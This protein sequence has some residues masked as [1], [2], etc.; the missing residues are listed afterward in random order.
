LDVIG[1]SVTGDIFAEPVGGLLPHM[2]AKKPST[3]K[4]AARLPPIQ[5]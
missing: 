4:T 1:R 3:R 5:I 2:M